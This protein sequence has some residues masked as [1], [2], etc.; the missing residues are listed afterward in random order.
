MSTI[1][2]Q[3][4]PPRRIAGLLLEYILEEIRQNQLKNRQ[5]FLYKVFYSCPGGDGENQTIERSN[6]LG[7]CL[8]EYSVCMTAQVAAILNPAD[9]DLAG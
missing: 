4:P 5:N 2:K 1:S 6:K 3:D 9:Q 7:E 8:H